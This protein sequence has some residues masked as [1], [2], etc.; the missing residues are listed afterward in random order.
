LIAAWVLA[1]IAAGVGGFLFA[2]RDTGET[3]PV[4]V[5]T[6]PKTVQPRPSS[7]TTTTRARGPITPVDPSA[8]IASSTRASGSDACTPPNPT[9]FAATNLTDGRSD[10]AWMPDETDGSPRVTLEFDTPVRISEIELVNGYPKQDPCRADLDRYYQ[11]MRPVLVSVDLHDGST[12][13]RL[14]VADRPS[15]Q[16]LAVSGTTD[17]ITLTILRSVPPDPSRIVT[18]TQ[19]PFSVPALGEI[20]VSGSAVGR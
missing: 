2:R 4:V 13:R 16:S 17:E 15:P 3:S 19:I 10:T 8:V 14:A 1:L 7:T 11:F 20:A 5:S 18:G 12:P 9:G 6:V